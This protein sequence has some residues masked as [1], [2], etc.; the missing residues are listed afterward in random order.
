LEEL[1]CPACGQPLEA[2]SHRCPH[3]GTE[4]ERAGLPD[5]LKGSVRSSL[6]W[7]SDLWKS[8]QEELDA[9]DERIKRA[10]RRIDEI[11]KSKKDAEVQEKEKLKVWLD[12]AMAERSR[13]EELCRDAGNALLAFSRLWSLPATVLQ[14][15]DEEDDLRRRME[16]LQERK[17][18]LSARKERMEEW[19]EAHRRVQRDLFSLA[20]GKEGAAREEGQGTEDM[21]PMVDGLVRRLEELGV[22]G[23][24]TLDGKVLESLRRLR[25]AL[26]AL[27]EGQEEKG[28]E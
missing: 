21:V 2:G 13:L 1:P 16:I 5:E 6:Q 7:L 11:R 28:R 17:E 19:W 22:D 3:C 20:L 23:G 8:Y 10:L 24:A 12:E 14:R 18:D 26:E 15:R 9:L 4:V 27:L 25:Q